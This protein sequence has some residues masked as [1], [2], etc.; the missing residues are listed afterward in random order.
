MRISPSGYFIVIV[1]VELG[2]AIPERI[3]VSPRFTSFGVFP[4]DNFMFSE[5]SL[6]S[7]CVT[8]KLII[9]SLPPESL[10][11]NSILSSSSISGVFDVNKNFPSLSIF[12]V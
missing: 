7:D 5:I 12:I 11:I 2:V 4:I 10:K 8:L 9:F 6:L 1:N 3:I